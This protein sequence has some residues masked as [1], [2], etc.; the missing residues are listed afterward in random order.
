MPDSTPNA[1]GPRNRTCL[2]YL[3][4]QGL[5]GDEPRPPIVDTSYPNHAFRQPI[6][7]H[8]ACVSWRKVPKGGVLE[9]I[10]EN[11]A[12]RRGRRAAMAVRTEVMST[13]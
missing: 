5:I 13:E 3:C 9:S 4:A 2:S 10:F 11:E 12:K 7:P 1:N 8:D 6:Q